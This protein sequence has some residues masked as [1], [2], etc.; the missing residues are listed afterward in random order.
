MI[1]LSEEPLA[2][3]LGWCRYAAAEYELEA[4][5]SSFVTSRVAVGPFGEAVVTP[6]EG[7]P[8][9]AGSEHPRNIRPFG[10]L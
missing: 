3:H 7:W 8:G 6:I 4:G 1:S 9:T 5:P 2:A 10:Q